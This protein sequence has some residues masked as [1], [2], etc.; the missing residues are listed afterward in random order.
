MTELLT[1]AARFTAFLRFNSAGEETKKTDD[2][3]ILAA[4]NKALREEYSSIFAQDLKR[5]LAGSRQ[6]VLD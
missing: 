5:D 2:P 1:N 6:G 4:K 3:V